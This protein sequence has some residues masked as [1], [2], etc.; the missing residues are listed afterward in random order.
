MSASAHCLSICFNALICIAGKRTQL[1]VG[2]SEDVT[3][4]QQRARAIRIERRFLASIQKKLS[5]R[6]EA[7][8]AAATTLYG[9]PHERPLRVRGFV[10]RNR[11]VAMSAPGSWKKT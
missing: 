3:E 8:I 10:Y 7:K 2:S 1:T 9:T 11:R 6:S 4:A 5:L